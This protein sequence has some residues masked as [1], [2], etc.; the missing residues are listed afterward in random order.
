MSDALSDGS[1]WDAMDAAPKAGGD[2]KALDTEVKLS[3][4]TCPGA[5]RCPCATDK[6][7]KKGL[8]IEDRDGSA[9]SQSCQQ[10]DGCL[11]GEG[12]IT[13]SGT[14]DSVCAPRFASLGA[15]CNT[16]A[17]CQADRGL[18]SATTRCAT[19][20]GHRKACVVSCSLT[21][22][23]PSGFYCQ[24]GTDYHC[25]PLPGTTC[26]CS[27]WAVHHVV[28]APCQDGCS[29]ELSCAKVG[30]LLS[31]LNDNG[32][33]ELCNKLDDNCDGKTDEGTV[34]CACGDLVCDAVKCGETI[35]N[36]SVDCSLCGDGICASGETPKTCAQDC[37]GG[38]GDGKCLLGCGENATSCPSD[39]GTA[40]GN[41]K[42][43]GGESPQTCAT[44]CA[45]FACGNK[46][47]D[48]GENPQNCPSDCGTPCGDCICQNGENGSSCPADCGYCGDG[49]CSNCG[50]AKAEAAGNCV[51]D[52]GPP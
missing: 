42:C 34:C 10:S 1:P 45:K 35:D 6:D 14:G 48:P 17:D 43:E 50:G 11:A 39:C 33:P 52:C 25:V 51:A 8:C 37:C 47:C 2:A 4:I 22:P 44:D 5:P 13:W 26:T 18:Q 15:P 30:Q 32:N 21:R 36:C 23:C 3:S 27:A 46:S 16:D 29:D 38:C 24:F 9:C 49:V 7:C 19:V 12:C 31:C 28:T 41:G 20:I 40:C